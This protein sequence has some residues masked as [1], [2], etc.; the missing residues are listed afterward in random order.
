MIILFLVYMPFF[1]MQQMD[2][3]T[4]KEYMVGEKLAISVKKEIDSAVM[5][6]SGY[7]RNFTLPEQIVSYNY[8]IIIENKTLSLRW[9]DKATEET[10]IAH[11]ITGNPQPG[12]NTIRNNNDVVYINV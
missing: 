5:F 7:R 10:L 2:I 1:W 4:E 3:E 9:K 12:F 6:G 8:V 11:N